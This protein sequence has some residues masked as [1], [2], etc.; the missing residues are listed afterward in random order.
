MRIS[1]R[2][3]PD[4]GINWTQETRLCDL[5]F[6]DDIALIAESREDLQQLTNNLEETAAKVSLR[7]NAKQTNAMQINCQTDM[8]LQLDGHSIEEVKHFIYLGS[9]IAADGNSESDINC[10]I[11]KAS[12]VFQRLQ[13][14]WKRNTINTSLKMQLFKSIVIPTAIY[15]SE[16][17]KNTSRITQKLDVF[18]QRCLRKILRVRYQDH[19]TNVEILRRSNSDKLSE[20]VTERRMRLAG[21]IIRLPSDRITKTAMSWIPP[22]GRRRRGRPAR[23]WRSTFK[24]DLERL[25][26]SWS[27]AEAVASD[28][29]NWRRIAAQ[30]AYEH[31]RT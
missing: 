10:R 30:C 18:Q 16:T 11:G 8:N 4:I 5:D 1:T 27:E 21:H 23:T 20:I 15:A 28:R 25:E 14:I 13:C 19:I 9:M 24:S 12:S 29:P 2:D 17:W 26:M 6:A 31:R 3:I 22:G 7:I